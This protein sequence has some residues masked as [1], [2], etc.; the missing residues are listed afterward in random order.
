MEWALAT[1]PTVARPWGANAVRVLDAHG[2]TIEAALP[3][4]EVHWVA[5]PGMS[6]LVAHMATWPHSPLAIE[7]LQRVEGIEMGQSGYTVHTI[8]EDPNSPSEG[9]PLAYPGFDGVVLAAP[10]AQA[11]A[12]LQASGMQA[13]WA[14]RITRDVR[15]APCW[16]LMAAFP[17]AAP[18]SPDAPE[19]PLGPQWSAARSTHHR[20]AWLARENSKPQHAGV[21]RWTVQASAAW[22]AEH[23]EDDA[24]RVK[25]KLLKAFA[26]ITGIR[27]AAPF[28]QVH[29]WRYAKTEA[30]LGQTHLWDAH[31]RIGLCG[32][33]CLGHRVEDAFLSGLSL[34]LDIV[35]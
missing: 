35:Q 4:R 8:D 34:A 24:E 11:V 32:D 28:A 17:N 20:V 1:A 22:S 18:T 30:A 25:A 27:A 33:W 26:E 13:D 7:M 10:H 5:Q 2:R 6:A 9:R 31:A 29:R 12:L 16:T 23:L 19:R 14:Q 21:E 15:V 3:K